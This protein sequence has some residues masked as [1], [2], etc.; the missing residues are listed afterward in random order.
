MTDYQTALSQC[1]SEQTATIASHTLASG[2]TV[3]V[4]KV[5][6]HVPQWRYAA[7]GLLSKVFKLGA[8]QPVPNLG[9][10]AALAIEARRLQ[11]LEQAGVPAPKL[12]AQSRKAI[13][14][15][16]LGANGFMHEIE[17]PA[18]Q[19]ASFAEG[20]AAI[21]RVHKAG[22]YL[23]QVFIRNIIR[24]SDGGIGFIDF[25]DDPLLHMQLLQCQC[26]DYL[27]YLQSSATWLERTGNL[28]ET[29]AIWCRHFQSLPENLQ[30]ALRKNY[31]RVLWL[32]KLT[33]GWMGSDTRRLSALA[34]LL[35]QAEKIQ[36]NSQ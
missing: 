4:R 34:Q 6:K 28:S 5:G 20:L 30:T 18:T 26:R 21:A 23:S 9:G 14:F 1:L 33:A 16:C 13:M 8:L 25:E 3:W 22:Q 35:Y 11:E 10:E 19:L 7:L 24:Q 29:V 15:S 17:N 27:C 12:L 36:Q 32:R 31:L 2:E